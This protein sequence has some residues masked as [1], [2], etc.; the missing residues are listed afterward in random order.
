MAL[1]DERFGDWKTHFGALVRVKF[2]MLLGTVALV[3]VWI[4]E[5]EEAEDRKEIMRMD[6]EK[7]TS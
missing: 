1:S 7:L 3:S 6:G 2:R 4:A 5:G